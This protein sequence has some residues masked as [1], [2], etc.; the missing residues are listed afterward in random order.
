MELGGLEPVPDWGRG[1]HP[2]LS[3]TGL[4]RACPTSG[5]ARGRVPV[6]LGDVAESSRR[7]AGHSHA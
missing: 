6:E 7:R 4:R 3:T 5:V 2:N 1:W